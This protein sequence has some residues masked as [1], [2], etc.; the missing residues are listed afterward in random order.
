M[1]NLLGTHVESIWNSFGIHKECNR[2]LYN[3]AHTHDTRQE[4][5]IPCAICKRE[6]CYKGHGAHIARAQAY[7]SC[8]DANSSCEC[9]A[10]L[11]EGLCSSL[12]WLVFCRLWLPLP[13]AKGNRLLARHATLLVM[14]W[15]RMMRCGGGVLCGCGVCEIGHCIVL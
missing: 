14:V 13:R 10:R 6:R 5:N 8:S 3:G 9:S 15:V 7:F 4:G 1:R 11:A 2:T 12:V